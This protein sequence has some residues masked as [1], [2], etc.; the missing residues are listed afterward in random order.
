MLLVL[1]QPY[2]EEKQHP[3]ESGEA[4]NKVSSFP[5][6]AAL[7]PMFLRKPLVTFFSVV[8]SLLR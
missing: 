7:R 8:P 6:N 4:E 1:C 2:L 3:G 5:L